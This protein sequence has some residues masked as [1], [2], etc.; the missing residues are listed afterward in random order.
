LFSL[1]N[2]VPIITIIFYLARKISK[3]S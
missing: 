1:Q 3:I 2:T